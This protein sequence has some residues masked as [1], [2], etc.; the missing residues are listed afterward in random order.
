MKLKFYIILLLFFSINISS[1]SLLKINHADLLKQSQGGGK[2]I[3]GKVDIEYDIYRVKCDSAVI[4]SDMTNARLFKNIQF[5][6]TS[7]TIRCER[8]V[9]SKTTAGRMAFLTGNI[10]ISE[11]D[12]FITGKE[13]SMNEIDDR[14]SVTDSV[15]VKYFKFPSVL[16][17]KELEMETK[18]NVIRSNTVD[19]VLYLD[20]LRFYKLLTRAFYYDAG[21]SVLKFDN[22]FNAESHEFSEPLKIPKKFDPEKISKT[23]KNLPVVKDGYFSA[24]KG[25]FRFDSLEIETSGKC[26]FRQID[27][28]VPDTLFFNSDKI[29]YS[30]KNKVADALGNVKIKKDKMLIETKHARF[31][32]QDKIV[33]FLEN[34]LVTYDNNTIRGDSI[35]LTVEGKDMYP[36]DAVIYGNPVFESLPDDKFPGEINILKGKLMNLW[37]SDKEISKIIVSKEAEGVYFIRREK[38]NVSEASNYLLGDEIIINF[39]DGE[40]DNA[41]IKG[42]CEGIY[43]PDKLKQ[44]ALKIKKK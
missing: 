20:S 15:I 21:K 37:F 2:I 38:K 14:V 5:S 4:N 8:A 42:G 40:I 6:D 36:K 32:E 16:F 44:N 35:S 43:Y 31:Y 3:Y 39:K 10:R 11:K 24:N 17:C 41:S 7:R 9:L 18:N 30:D 12:F 25:R 22:R 1:Q 13:A 29:I 27:R 33:K 34:P 26:F 19:S 28:T 23:V